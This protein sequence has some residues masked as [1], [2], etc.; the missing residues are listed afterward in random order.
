MTINNINEDENI[1]YQLRMMASK[2]SI[3]DDINNINRGG[4]L[5]ISIEDEN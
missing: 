3:E 5:T 2:I 1:Q 4:Q